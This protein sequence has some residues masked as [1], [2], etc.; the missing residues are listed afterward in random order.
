MI[1]YIDNS[2]VR[3]RILQLERLNSQ[4]RVRFEGNTCVYR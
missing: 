2:D 3:N 1:A 4:P